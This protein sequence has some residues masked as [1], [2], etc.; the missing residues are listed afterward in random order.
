MSSGAS[1]LL[2]NI[3]SLKQSATTILRYKFSPNKSG[4]CTATA[5]GGVFD[6]V[7]FTT[8]IFFLTTPFIKESLKKELKSS[9]E[10]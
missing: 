5:G 3:P 8:Q 1:N 7:V 6:F 4:S 2:N 9:E 10:V